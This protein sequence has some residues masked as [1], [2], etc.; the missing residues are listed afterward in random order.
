MELLIESLVP[1]FLSVNFRNSEQETYTQT[2]HL[3]AA[4]TNMTN[5]SAHITAYETT[6]RVFSFYLPQSH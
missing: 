2:C 3:A 5:K 1:L 6:S 4:L